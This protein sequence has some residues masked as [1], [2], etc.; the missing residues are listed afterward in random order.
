MQGWVVVEPMSF[1]TALSTYIHCEI[2]GTWYQN[3]LFLMVQSSLML[4]WTLYNL[5]T[6]PEAQE[7]LRREVQGV[8]GSSDVVTPDHIS[9][10][11]YLHNC[12]KETL[13][14]NIS[15]LA[16]YTITI[17]AYIIIAT[18]DCMT[19]SVC[20]SGSFQWLLQTADSFRKMWCSQGIL[21]QLV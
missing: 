14:Y 12:V 19:C 9:K 8:V 2:I 11:P 3:T 15:F 5:A 18:H 4:S 1:K 13:R 21:Y 16:Q 10:M 20:V 7:R 6:N 17:S